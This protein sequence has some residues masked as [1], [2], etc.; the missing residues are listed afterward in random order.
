MRSHWWTR[1]FLG[2]RSCCPLSSVTVLSSAFIVQFC[3][4]LR[5]SPSNHRSL[6]RTWNCRGKASLSLFLIEQHVLT[7][8]E[9]FSAYFSCRKWSIMPL[10]MLRW[11]HIIFSVAIGCEKSPDYFS[12]ENLGIV[13]KLC[14]TSILQDV[15][16]CSSPPTIEKWSSFWINFIE[17]QYSIL[18][19]WRFQSHD[20]RI[21]SQ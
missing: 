4:F 21:A 7:W 16:K 2:N 8:Q 1:T 10:S 3:F 12:F 19:S 15:N 6:G 14:G 9:S 20:H 5:L 11:R 18:C 13:S 17:V